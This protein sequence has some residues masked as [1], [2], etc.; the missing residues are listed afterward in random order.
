MPIRVGRGQFA[1]R[2]ELRY[3]FAGEIPADG[4]EVLPELLFVTQ[5]DS[6]AGH[7]GRFCKI[8]LGTGGA[9]RL[10]RRSYSKDFIRPQISP[11]YT[12]KRK[13]LSETLRESVICG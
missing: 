4:A 10:N 1:R 13:S 7:G 8:E 5:A 11:I 6:D 9:L 3:V 2:I 12:E